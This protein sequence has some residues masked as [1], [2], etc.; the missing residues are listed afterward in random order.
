MK[1]TT[2]FQLWAADHFELCFKDKQDT[3]TDL[4]RVWHVNLFDGQGRL[5]PQ[6]RLLLAGESRSFFATECDHWRGLSLDS[7]R[8]G[9]INSLHDVIHYH[10]QNIQA[11]EKYWIGK[12]IKM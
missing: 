4:G 10:K 12:F 5:K 2:L 11:I 7:A 1:S 3:P 6:F 9:G 8:S